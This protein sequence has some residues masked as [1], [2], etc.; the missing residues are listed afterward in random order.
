M[1]LTPEELREWID[2]QAEQVETA[3]VLAWA[4]GGLR[5]LADSHRK[6]VKRLAVLRHLEEQGLAQ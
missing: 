2:W 5:P 6:Q 1:E 3:R 4:S